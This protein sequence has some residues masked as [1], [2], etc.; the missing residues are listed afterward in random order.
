MTYKPKLEAVRTG[1][2]TQTIRKGTKIR[3]GDEILFHSWSGRPYASPWGWRLR[4][5]VYEVEDCYLTEEKV[6]FHVPEMAVHLAWDDPSVELRAR[7]D[8]IDP[9]TGEGLKNVL[10]GKNGK[11]WEGEYQIIRWRVIG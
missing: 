9:P 5:K 6:V 10:K 4:V 11:D 7:W 8:Y 1:K 3:V 2:C